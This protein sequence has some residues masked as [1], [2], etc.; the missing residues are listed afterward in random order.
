MSRPIMCFA[1][2]KRSP[3]IVFSVLFERGKTMVSIQKT[4]IDFFFGKN[5]YWVLAII[6]N[7][8]ALGLS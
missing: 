3:V 2:E 8:L 1:L 4:T 5:H 7:V 6:Q